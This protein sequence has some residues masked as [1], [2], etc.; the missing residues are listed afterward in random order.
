MQIDVPDPDDGP[1]RTAPEA[2]VAEV[3]DEL[4]ALTPR[5]LE[6]LGELADGRTNR[7]IAERLFISEKTVGVHVGRIYDKIGVHS[8]VQA[9]AVFR[10]SANGGPAAGPVG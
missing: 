3:V 5:E 2:C 7:Q 9:S 6:V 8:R 10:R 1:A 4:A